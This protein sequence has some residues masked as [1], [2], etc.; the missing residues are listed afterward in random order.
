MPTSPTEA[1]TTA[2]PMGA[3]GRGFSWFMQALGLA[4]AGAL[5]AP[6]IVTPP[7]R[8]SPASVTILVAGAVLVLA[9]TTCIGI[10]IRH[11]AVM[12]T[13][14]GLEYRGVGYRVRA[15]WP[16]VRFLGSGQLLVEQGSF[17]PQSWMRILWPLGLLNG[18]AARAHAK[19]RLVHLRYYDDAWPDGRLAADLR[20]VAPGLLPPA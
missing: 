17:E 6:V 3:G 20:R 4:G 1:P 16:A 11:S 9:L 7:L 14:E 10:E 19:A 5:L 12:L 18:S 13:P 15:A 2:H 8:D